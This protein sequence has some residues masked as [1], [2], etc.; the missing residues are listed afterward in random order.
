[1]N[2]YGSSCSPIFTC[3]TWGMAVVAVGAIDGLPTGWGRLHSTC[4]S[5]AC[6]CSC[7]VCSSWRAWCCVWWMPVR[8]LTIVASAEDS[9]TVNLPQRPGFRHQ[10]NT[11]LGWVENEE[12]KG[13]PGTTQKGCLYSISF[14]L[15]LSSQS[16][17]SHLCTL[18]PCHCSLKQRTFVSQILHRCVILTTHFL[19]LHPPFTVLDH[20]PASTYFMAFLSNQMNILLPTI[21]SIYQ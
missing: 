16:H 18:Y 7:S 12:R 5:S 21:Y 14:D 13:R 6:T 9:I 8:V 19:C 15:L 10:C 11:F 4:W 2:A 17:G 1:M 3:V 20:A